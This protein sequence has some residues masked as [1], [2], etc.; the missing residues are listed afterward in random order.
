MTMYWFRS[1]VTDSAQRV[2]R[3]LTAFVRQEFGAPIATIMGLTEILIEDARRRKDESLA[4]DLDRIHSAGRLLQEQLDRLVSLATQ[5]YLGVG[6]DSTAL[7]TTLRHDLRT[8]L[9]A[10]KGYSELILEDAR[11]NGREDL[12]TDMTKVVA[13]ADQLLG[14]IDRLI[15][16][17][18]EVRSSD[19]SHVPGTPHAIWSA[20]L[21]DQFNR[22]CLDLKRIFCRAG[23]WW[24]TTRKP[25]GI[26]FRA[27]FAAKAMR[28]IPPMAEDQPWRRCPNP[29]LISFCLI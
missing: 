28:L 19:A 4:L 8:P 15:G 6:D 27:G 14:Q 22:S 13:A 7:R 21:C 10:V 9:N 11:D 5:G 17:T 16:L 12:L 1:N 26:C 2:E 18:E 24:L 20:R 23:S 3:A 29:S 25:I